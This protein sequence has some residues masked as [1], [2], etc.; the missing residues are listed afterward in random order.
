MQD[1]QEVIIPL[2]SPKSICTKHRLSQ[3]EVRVDYLDLR[4]GCEKGY[5][6]DC[7]ECIRGKK[8]VM[9]R[10]GLEEGVVQIAKWG[11]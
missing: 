1:M 8:G 11:F 3:S 5:G 10:S 6:R 4:L 9:G 2:T 7:T